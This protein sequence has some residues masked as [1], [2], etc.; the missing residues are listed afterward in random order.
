M[1]KDEEIRVLQRAI[2][3]LQRSLIFQSKNDARCCGI[4]F[5]QCHALMEIGNDQSITLNNLASLLSLN[6]STLSRTVDSMVKGDL[7]KREVNPED[8]RAV[9]ITLTEKGK[10]LY[11]SLNCTYDSFYRNIMDL[12]PAEKQAQVIDSIALL[13]GAVIKTGYDQCCE[14]DMKS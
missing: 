11:D 6:N 2:R 3:Q 7:V 10:L 5:A 4:T 1:V 14:E 9:N 8:R 12:I 13:A